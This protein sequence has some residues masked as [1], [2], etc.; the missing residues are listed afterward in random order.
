MVQLN[1]RVRNKGKS[2]IAVGTERTRSTCCIC[3]RYFH[4]GK[5]KVGTKFK[6]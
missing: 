5:K 1:D 6:H 4:P 2:H 3:M